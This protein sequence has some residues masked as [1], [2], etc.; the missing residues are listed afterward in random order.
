MRDVCEATVGE[1]RQAA[2]CRKRNQHVQ[3]R[4]Y[5]LLVCKDPSALRMAEHVPIQ[6]PGSKQQPEI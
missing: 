2:K 5:T 3:T 6:L 1:K 4:K